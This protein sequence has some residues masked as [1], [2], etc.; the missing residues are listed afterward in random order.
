M[1]DTVADFLTRIRNATRVKHET[2]EI[3]YSNFKWALAK[4]FEDSGFIESVKKKGRKE[5]RT[6]E[7][8]LRYENANPSIDF[9]RRVSRPGR[10]VYTKKTDIFPMR[11]G[12][13]R[14]ISTPQGL[15][16][17]KEARKKGQGGE[18]ICEIG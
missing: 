4:I 1:T 2:V 12:R 15:M 10:R 8:K 13:V 7:I 17:D 18:I 5:K 9:L 14:I 6:I 16:T 3:P 11:G